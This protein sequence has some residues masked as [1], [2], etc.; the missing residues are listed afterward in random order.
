MAWML[1]FLDLMRNFDHQVEHFVLSARQTLKKIVAAA[2]ET[3]SIE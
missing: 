1:L 2:R 3:S